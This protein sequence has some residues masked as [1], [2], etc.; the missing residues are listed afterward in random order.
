V[1]GKGMGLYLVKTEVEL[2]EGKI[3]VTSEVNQGATFLIEFPE[4]V[5]RQNSMDI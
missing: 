3:A 5:T 1:D 4:P 2:L